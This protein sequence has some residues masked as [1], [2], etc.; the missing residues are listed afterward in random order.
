[1]A[2]KVLV[3]LNLEQNEL[4]NA[5]IQNLASD[6]S[7]ALAGQV[8]FNT[9]TGK[10][11]IFDGTNWQE[12]GSG[13]GTVTSIGLADGGG[14]TISDSP[15][16][17]SGTITVGHTNQI[18]AETTSGIYPIKVDGYGHITEIGTAFDPTD[19]AELASPAFTGTPTAPTAA[20][21]TNTTQIATTEFVQTAVSDLEGSMHYK[22]TVSGG[23]LPSS[24]VEN[25]DTYKVAEAGT[26]D[27]QAAKVGDLF[28]AVVSGSTVTW[29]YVPSGDDTGMT[30]LTAGAGLNTTSDDS[31]V[32]GGTITSTGTLYLTKSGVTAGTYN[33]VTVDKYGRVTAGTEETLIS[34]YAETITGDA[35]ATTFTITHNLG[36][37]DVTVQVYD[38]TTN[39]DVVVDITRTS[40]SAVTIGFAQAPASTDSYRVV[41]IG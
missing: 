12:M 13:G 36:S 25:G 11:R 33:S 30:S 4:Q 5:V 1:M 31:S 14:L 9:T 15:V 24:D 22:G 17:T 2:K 29:T 7:N 34:K 27:G 18:T 38:A 19:Y 41:V 21:G 37:R 6:P 40:T 26:Y 10:F 32:D 20:A 39:E 23:T 35:S 28:I 8:Y 16:I 3:D